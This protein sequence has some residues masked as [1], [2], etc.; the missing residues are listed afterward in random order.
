METDR[1]QIIK[2]AKKLAADVALYL[3]GTGAGVR[4]RT[5]ELKEAAQRELEVAR[6]TAMR[7][8]KQVNEAAHEN[9][10]VAAGIAAAVGALAAL[11]FSRRNRD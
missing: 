3:S 7:K 1:D 6:Q 2:D 8:A 10:W 4:E 5:H 9:P 11:F